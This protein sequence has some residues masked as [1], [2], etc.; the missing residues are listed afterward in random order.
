M[1]LRLRLRLLGCALAGVVLS[2]SAAL[3]SSLFLFFVVSRRVWCTD[4]DVASRGRAILLQE[5]DELLLG[6]N[7]FRGAGMT[8]QRVHR[9]DL[10]ILLKAPVLI[11]MSQAPNPDSTLIEA[12]EQENC[13]W[14]L[15][16]AGYDYVG[17]YCTGLPVQGSR[18]VGSEL[19]GEILEAKDGNLTPVE[20]V[21]LR[22]LKQVSMEAVVWV[23]RTDAFHAGG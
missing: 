8:P 9:Y 22:V 14:A 17:S 12:V 11:T 10:L 18:R 3:C 2:S 21:L 6:I 13:E 4:P 7:L 20:H 5:G 19:L 16:P 1:Q 23:A 15:A